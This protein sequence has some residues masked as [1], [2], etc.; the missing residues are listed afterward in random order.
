VKEAVIEF[1]E[2]EQKA[3][4]NM[5]RTLVTFVPKWMFVPYSVIK[6]NWD[7]VIDKNKKEDGCGH[8]GRS[9]EK[10]SWQPSLHPNYI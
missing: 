4:N 3:K 7:A 10:R 5:E 6:I 9:R 8:N 1:Y 2:A